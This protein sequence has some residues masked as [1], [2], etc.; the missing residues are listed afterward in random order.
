METPKLDFKL[1]KKKRE[2][3]SDSKNKDECKREEETGKWTKQKGAGLMKIALPFCGKS[4][5][6]SNDFFCFQF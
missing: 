6:K 5:S 1:K 2:R 3:E 4:E